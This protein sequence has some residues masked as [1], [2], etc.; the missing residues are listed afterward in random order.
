VIG[1]GSTNP[2][3][4]LN[5]TLAGSAAFTNGTSYQC[6]AMYQANAAGT[7]P[8]AFHGATAT[9]F[10]FKGDSSTTVSFICVGN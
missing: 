2:G 5:V 8:L 3:G 1:S 6:T 9:G 4:V 10:M 7:A